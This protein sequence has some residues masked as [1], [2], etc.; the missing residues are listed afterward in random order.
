MTRIYKKFCAKC[1]NIFMSHSMFQQIVTIF[2]RRLFERAN[3]DVNMGWASLIS[4]VAY[5]FKLSYY[6]G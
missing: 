3:M 2:V 5:V 6:M 4:E 1:S